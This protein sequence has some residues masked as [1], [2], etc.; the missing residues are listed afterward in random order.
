MGMRW[1]EAGAAHGSV[2]KWRLIITIRNV[3]SVL[4]DS[5]GSSTCLFRTKTFTHVAIKIKSTNN[6]MRKT[7]EH[8]STRP[9]NN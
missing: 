8:R 5:S 2:T 3:A 7:S 4:I 1:D 9:R 6:R